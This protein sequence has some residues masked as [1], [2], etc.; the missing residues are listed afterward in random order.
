MEG[1]RRGVPSYIA[2]RF[3]Q[4][5]AD[6][7]SSSHSLLDGGD[8][9][10]EESVTAPLH[11]HWPVLHDGGATRRVNTV[12]HIWGEGV[13]MGNYSIINKGLDSENQSIHVACRSVATSPKYSSMVIISSGSHMTRK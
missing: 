2:G 3:P 7:P 13:G 6:A 9:A 1:Q 5:I 11:L 10:H 12:R 8:E 4:D